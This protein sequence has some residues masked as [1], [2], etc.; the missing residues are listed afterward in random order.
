VPHLS[1]DLLPAS[2]P[3]LAAGFGCCCFSSRNARDKATGKAAQLRGRRSASS[4]RGHR[5]R[6]LVN[7]RRSFQCRYLSAGTRGKLRLALY[8]LYIWGALSLPVILE[9]AL[10]IRLYPFVLIGQL[11]DSLTTAVA[12]VV[13]TASWL[14]R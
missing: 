4:F 5:H 3:F 11:L 2:F 10:F 1:P 6:V 7:A 13:A 14:A 9:S 8:T 12:F